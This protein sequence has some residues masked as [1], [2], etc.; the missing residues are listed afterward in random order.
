MEHV[1]SFLLSYQEAKTSPARRVR[2]QRLWITRTLRIASS[3]TRTVSSPALAK[4]P[5]REPIAHKAAWQEAPL[6]RGRARDSLAHMTC[7][8]MGNDAHFS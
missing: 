3:T 7:I 6:W 1:A 5:G 8:H 4:G 2:H